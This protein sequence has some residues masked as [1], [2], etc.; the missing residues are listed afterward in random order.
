M[1]LFFRLKAKL[2]FALFARVSGS[3][4]QTEVAA[5]ILKIDK[6]CIMTFWTWVFYAIL[7]IDEN[8]IM[9]FW[10]GFLRFF[11]KKQ[12]LYHEFL[13]GFFAQF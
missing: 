11:K 3:G 13:D 12:T 9:T 2:F 4:R 7:K 8:C 10:T 6:K 1:N 5:A